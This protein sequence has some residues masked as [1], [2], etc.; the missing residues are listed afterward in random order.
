MTALV[1]HGG[2]SRA[3]CSCPVPAVSVRRARSAEFIGLC[4]CQ[5]VKKH[6]PAFQAWW[7]ECRL[8]DLP[9]ELLTSIVTALT[10]SPILALT[11]GRRGGVLCRGR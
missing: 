8:R 4:C 11:S 1:P 9:A 10:P 5:A 2:S 6:V 7:R 3:R